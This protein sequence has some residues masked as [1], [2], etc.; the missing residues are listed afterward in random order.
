MIST[1]HLHALKIIKEIFTDN[2]IEWKLVGS[3][4][5]ALQGVMIEPKDIDIGISRDNIDQ[6]QNLLREYCLQ[7]IQ[8][9][10][11]DKFRSF[12]G[13]F[14]LLGIKVEIMADLEICVDDT[15]VRS[16]SMDEPVTFIPM[17]GCTFPCV[18]LP[19]SY[20]TYLK[21]GRMET[22]ERIKSVLDNS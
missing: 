21:M 18:S 6:V 13:K 3:S 7:P 22:A 4:G 1:K 19:V 2:S 17:D 9:S 8:F 16:L 5:L 20:I 11:T 14:E 10:S 12:I 15:W